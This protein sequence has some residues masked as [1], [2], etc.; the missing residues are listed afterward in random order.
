[1]IV[2]RQRRV[3]H[4]RARGRAIHTVAAQHNVVDLV[5]V[6]EQTQRRLA[7]LVDIAGVLGRVVF[8]IGVGFDVIEPA[9]YARVE[10]APVVNRDRQRVVPLLGADRRAGRDVIV[11]PAR[12]NDAR[13]R[14]GIDAR[15][16]IGPGER[17]RH[18]QHQ[19]HPAH[20]RLQAIQARAARPPVGDQQAEIERTHQH[21]ARE[22]RQQAIQLQVVAHRHAEN[23]ALPRE[24][25]RDPEP[26][27][28]V[29]QRALQPRPARARPGVP[30]AAC[31]LRPGPEPGQPGRQ[32]HR[33]AHAPDHH[34]LQGEQVAH[35]PD[36][37]LAGRRVGLAIHRRADFLNIADKPRL[38]T[39]IKERAADECVGLQHAKGQQRDHARQRHH[40][41]GAPEIEASSRGDVVDIAGWR[42]V[43]TRGPHALRH[44]QHRQHAQ[45]RHCYAA[46]HCRA[47][48]QTEQERGWP[49]AI[50]R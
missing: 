41:G 38:D 42:N 29:A 10:G 11:H 25:E 18:H 23:T 44:R 15:E 39:Q 37:L 30:Q 36:P 48:R 3:A 12:R 6:V 1:M 49:A 13:V 17:Q 9:A 14:A 20:H 33:N 28:R 7:I 24:V 35:P 46:G 45:R 34:I 22:Q 32:A 26:R 21:P 2:A 4:R 31:Q 47:N 19:R 8:G 40:A 16:G 5:E 50:L 43:V 27:Q